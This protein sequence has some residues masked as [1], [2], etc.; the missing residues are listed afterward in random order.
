MEMRRKGKNDQWTGF[1]TFEEYQNL[2]QFFIS[3]KKSEAE[4]TV[5][6]S[7]KGEIVR[8]RR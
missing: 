5:R 3:Q 2:I 4:R 6:E 7:G 8:N 1:S